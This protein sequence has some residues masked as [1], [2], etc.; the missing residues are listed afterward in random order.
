MM[1]LWV[2]A[3]IVGIVGLAGTVELLYEIGF[4]HRSSPIVGLVLGVW[5]WVPLTIQAIR[6]QGLSP[7]WFW[8][9]VGTVGGP[10]ALVP[11]WHHGREWKSTWRKVVGW[12]FFMAV[13]AYYVGVFVWAFLSTIASKS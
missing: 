12:L 3:V 8:V 10:L 2:W 6:R 1:G 5:I 4:E 7:R 13:I 9:T 11:I